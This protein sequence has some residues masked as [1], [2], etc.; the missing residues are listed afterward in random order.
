MQTPK[1]HFFPLMMGIIDSFITKNINQV[2]DNPK[3]DILYHTPLLDSTTNCQIIIQIF[4]IKFNTWFF[5]SEI[6]LG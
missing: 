6:F 5:N 2:W 1:I 3:I 4:N